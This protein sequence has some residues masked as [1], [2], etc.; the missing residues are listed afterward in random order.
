MEACYD[1]SSGSLQVSTL[2][3]I[4]S[5]SISQVCNY[6]RAQQYISK[7]YYKKNNNKKIKSERER[8]RLLHF[9]DILPCSFADVRSNKKIIG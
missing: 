9:L 7:I 8:E 5:V 6:T 1:N 2:H 4:E 3:Y